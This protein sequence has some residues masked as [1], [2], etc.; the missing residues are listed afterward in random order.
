MLHVGAPIASDDCAERDEQAAAMLSISSARAV[1]A[2]TI[3]VVGEAMEQYLMAKLGWER[4]QLTRDAM[5][6]HLQGQDPAL[7]ASWD[8]IWVACEM[9]RYGAS[10]GNLDALAA[11]LIALAETTESTLS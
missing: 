5:R 4:S 6:S 10:Q 8:G 1:K 9:Q 2:K 7:G 3:E 11:Q